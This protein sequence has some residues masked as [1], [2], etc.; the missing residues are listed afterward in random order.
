MGC[1]RGR[2]GHSLSFAHASRTVSA[3]VVMLMPP[4]WLRVPSINSTMASAYCSDGVSSH[5]SPENHSASAGKSCAMRKSNL[6]SACARHVNSRW[7]AN[8]WIN[9]LRKVAGVPG[10]RMTMVADSGRYSPRWSSSQ[11]ACRVTGSTQ[12]TRPGITARKSSQ[13]SSASSRRSSGTV[14]LWRRSARVS[15]PHAGIDAMIAISNATRL[16]VTRRE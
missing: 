3:A 4:R 13:A 6:I 5:D 1:D 16:R 14:S 8:S 9:S 7:W 10:T 2:S 15:P 12:E 11:A